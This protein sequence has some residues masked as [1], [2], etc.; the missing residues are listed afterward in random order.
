MN[1]GV[2]I[3]GAFLL[4]A[5][6]TFWVNQPEP[7]PTTRPPDPD[8][9]QGRKDRSKLRQ[10]WFNTE[11]RGRYVSWEDPAAHARDILYKDGI[12]GNGR[13]TR[14]PTPVEGGAGNLPQNTPLFRQF[15]I[16]QTGT[17]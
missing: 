16:L 8:T 5:A 9:P 7:D 14:V 3:A 11:G 4:L 1:T 6:Y 13:Y 2:I 10:R 17:C 15:K 12:A